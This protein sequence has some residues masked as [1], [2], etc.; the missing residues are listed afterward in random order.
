MSHDSKKLPV[1]FR[2][3]KGPPDID[4]HTKEW[5]SGTRGGGKVPAD[6]EWKTNPKQHQEENGSNQE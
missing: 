3:P 4:H 5:T 1:P 2:P 6:F